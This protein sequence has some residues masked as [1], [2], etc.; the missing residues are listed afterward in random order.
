MGNL[1]NPLEYTGRE[2]RKCPYPSCTAGEVSAEH[3]VRR[4]FA[5]LGVNIDEPKEVAAFQDTVKFA[6]RLNK[7]LDRS[8]LAFFVALATCLAGWVAYKFG[9]K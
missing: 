8:V 5:I 6:G 7:I 4:V 9:F 3:A 2:R 1:D